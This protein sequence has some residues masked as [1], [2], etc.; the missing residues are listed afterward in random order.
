[1]DRLLRRARLSLNLG[2]ALLLLGLAGL[3][4]LA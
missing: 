3:L 4:V 2:L 1:M